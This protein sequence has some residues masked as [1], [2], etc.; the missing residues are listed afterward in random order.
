MQRF[1]KLAMAC[2]ERSEGFRHGVIGVEKQLDKSLEAT[3]GLAPPDALLGVVP[4][5]DG[6]IH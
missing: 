3:D 2:R 1:F 5:E 4:C 6:I